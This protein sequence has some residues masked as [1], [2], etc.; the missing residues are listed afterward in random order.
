MTA[1]YVKS[2]PVPASFCTEHLDEAAYQAAYDTGAL[3]LAPSP[4]AS[5]EL[6]AGG[7]KAG[8]AAAE[9]S[10]AVEP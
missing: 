8:A 10:Y 3:P 6:A 4:A 1:G 9:V 5:D 7:V 2:F